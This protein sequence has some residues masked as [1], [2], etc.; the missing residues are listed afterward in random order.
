MKDYSDSEDFDIDSVWNEDKSKRGQV[1][2]ASRER[3][4]DLFAIN[5]KR[6]DLVLRITMNDDNFLQ[7][8]DFTKM[9]NCVPQIDTSQ[10]KLENWVFPNA[11][12]REEFFDLRFRLTKY[13]FEKMGSSPNAAVV[14]SNLIMGKLVYGINYGSIDGPLG[15]LVESLRNQ[16]IE[17]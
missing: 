9:W 15:R 1:I 5:I 11:G 2:V 7:V 10:A 6:G 8:Q 12:E 16:V 3:S 17:G 13:F 14:I 4:P